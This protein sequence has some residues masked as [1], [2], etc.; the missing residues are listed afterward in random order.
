MPVAIY[1][2]PKCAKCREALGLL[3]DRG[4]KPRVIEYLKNPPSE[5]ELRE[6]LKL[7]GLKPRGLLRTKEPEYAQAGLDNPELS[8]DAIIR[9]MLKYPKLIERPIVISGNRAALGRPPQNI[10]KIL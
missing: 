6:L 2:N 7:L 10:L 8:D 4:I 3:T 1:Y 9:A 5:T